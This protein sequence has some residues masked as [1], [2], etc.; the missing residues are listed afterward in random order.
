M[1]AKRG[2]A[3]NPKNW[4]R[5]LTALAQ[6]LESVESHKVDWRKSRHIRK[7]LEEANAIPH[8]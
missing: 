3:S 8:P 7:S 6:L 5:R 4:R 2:R 1:S